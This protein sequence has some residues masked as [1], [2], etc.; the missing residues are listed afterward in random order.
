MPPFRRKA[1]YDEAALYDYAVEAL[2]RRM[3]SV[4][5]LKRLL[6]HRV[7]SQN[8]ADRLVET[9]VGRLKE[10]RY[11]N[12][13]EFAAAYIGYRRENEKFGRLRVI[14]DLK[15]KGVHRDV[16][17]K[18]VGEAYAQADEE[19]LARQFLARRRILKPSGD[20]QAAKVFRSLVRGGFTRQTSL[21]I[22]KKWKVDDEVIAALETE[23]EDTAGT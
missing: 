6:R 16:I 10:R 2:G 20:K 14:R 17:E 5:E 19:D 11:L 12:D 13:T 15:N 3:R 9:V 22:L 8:D 1:V 23:S 21:A 4:A 18:S 7:E